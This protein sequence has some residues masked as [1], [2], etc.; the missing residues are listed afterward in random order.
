MNQTGSIRDAAKWIDKA[1]WRPKFN[2]IY[3]RK[4]DDIYSY[5]SIEKPNMYYLQ[6][7]NTG[8]TCLNFMMQ[9]SSLSG[10][11]K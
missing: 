11:Y 10:T 6:L 1:Q 5:G 4:C 8:E 7:Q 3:G 2:S 9:T